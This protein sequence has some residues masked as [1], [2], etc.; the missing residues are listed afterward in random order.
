MFYLCNRELRIDLAHDATLGERCRKL[1]NFLRFHQDPS[2][3]SSKQRVKGES[4][5]LHTTCRSRAEACQGDGDDG[6]VLE[7]DS[8][9][10]CPSAERTAPPRSTHVRDGRRLLRLDPARKKERLR[11]A[12]PRAARRRGA[13]GAA[14]FRQ[15]FAEHVR[16]RRGVGEGR[17]CALSCGVPAL[18]SPLYI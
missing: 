3:S 7:R 5:H 9:H 10:R 12:A 1:K 6:V 2:M 16:R 15:S 18:P 8:D 11:K 17:G 14:V 13:V 4:L